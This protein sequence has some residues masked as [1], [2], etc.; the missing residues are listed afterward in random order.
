MVVVVVVLVLISICVFVFLA[1]S[2]SLES[3][4]V[5]RVYACVLLMRSFIQLCLFLGTDRVWVSW[6]P[7]L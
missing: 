2:S 4:P 3:V 5:L 6:E 7:N 1:L